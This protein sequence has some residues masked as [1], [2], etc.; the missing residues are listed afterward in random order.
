MIEEHFE[1]PVTVYQLDGGRS[2]VVYGPW[3]VVIRGIGAQAEA[4]TITRW[5]M[6]AS[7]VVSMGFERVVRELSPAVASGV[8]R[9]ASPE[10]PRQ[11]RRPWARA[12]G[13]GFPPASFACGAHPRC[14]SSAPA[15]YACG[16]RAKPSWARR[17]S[18][19]SREEASGAGWGRANP[20]GGASETR[21]GSSDTRIGS[22]ERKARS[23]Y[24]IDDGEPA[25]SHKGG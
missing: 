22:S 12:S 13:A 11:L 10:M 16:A 3:Q 20:V 9:A 23:P 18:A 15:S 4:R 2:R 17:A 19:A 1:G 21:L 8:R 14:T 24:A 6:E 25:P 7:W 5:E